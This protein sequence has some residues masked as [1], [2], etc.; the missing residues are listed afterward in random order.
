MPDPPPAPVAAFE[1]MPKSF[2]EV[3]ALFDRRREA[4]LHSHL[5]AH[6]HLVHFEPGR[7]EFH[8]TPEAPRDL[9]NRLGQLLSE[10][11]GTRWLIAI[12]EA[13]GEPTLRQ[14]QERREAELRNGVA[15]HPL[16]KA[17]L[18][19]FPGAT[20]TAVRERFAASADGEID[21]A[22]ETD[23]EAGEADEANPEEDQ[24]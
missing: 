8:P 19:T 17:V 1:P 12:T 23:D 14:G 4:V 13:E 7:I 10:W 21:F 5:S 3:V 24:I 15:A 2:D 6:V 22:G 11:T 9:A 20:I 18:E 16:V